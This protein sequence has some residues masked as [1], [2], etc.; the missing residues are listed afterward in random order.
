MKFLLL[1][2]ALF[3]LVFSSLHSQVKWRQFTSQDGLSSD[4]V[5]SIY[6]SSIGDIWIGTDMG[7]DFFSGV[8]ENFI[9]ITML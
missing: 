9:S 6:E 3:S 7:T 5:L 2:I 1:P 8:S 4:V